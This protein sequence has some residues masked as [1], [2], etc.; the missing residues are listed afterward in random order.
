MDTTNIKPHELRQLMPLL[1]NAR[2]RAEL[3]AEADT[4][5]VVEESFE[6]L[7]MLHSAL[8]HLGR[9]AELEASV[10][11]LENENAALDIQ[12]AIF[13]EGNSRDFYGT[14]V[15]QSAVTRIIDQGCEF[16]RLHKNALLGKGR[17]KHLV[18]ARQI[19]MWVLRTVLL[20]DFQSIGRA[21]EMHHSSVMHCV[22]K[23]ETLAQWE[24]E[25]SERM[26]G[27]KAIIQKEGAKR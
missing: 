6:Q 8:H 23:V 5:H 4:K 2:K 24:E 17:Q 26:N 13:S 19:I 9:A 20:M 11:R 21:F 7:W 1:E 25:L 15:E 16:F 12:A 10:S 18:E 3:A 27:F 14:P 22:R